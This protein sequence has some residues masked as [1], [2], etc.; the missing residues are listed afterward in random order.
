MKLKTFSGKANFVQ[1]IIQTGL[2]EKH[3]WRF[4]FE[5][6]T[7]IFGHRAHVCVICVLM[8]V[9]SVLNF[10]CHF[11]S[12]VQNQDWHWTCINQSSNTHWSF[13]VSFLFIDI[14]FE[15]QLITSTQHDWSPRNQMLIALLQA[16]SLNMKHARTTR[17]DWDLQ[18]IR[19]H[20]E[21]KTEGLLKAEVSS[22]TV[23]L[24]PAD[25][26]RLKSL[27]QRI[28]LSVVQRLLCL[29]PHVSA[30]LNIFRQEL[31]SPF[32]HH[33]SLFFGN[34]IFLRNF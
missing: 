8:K 3:L 18:R 9:W 22:R 34:F 12:N 32:P 15:Q 28:W 1:C 14:S 11:A 2:N 26:L 10:N 20:H 25:E 7:S 16:K 6:H 24:V 21:K 30:I 23:F 19:I 31:F 5:W 13:V 33:S 27:L 4:L 17:I 29:S